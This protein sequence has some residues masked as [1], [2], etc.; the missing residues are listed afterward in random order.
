MTGTFNPENAS[1]TDL[2]DSLKFKDDYVNSMG[3]GLA[4]TTGILSGI[5]ALSSGPGHWLAHLAAG[6]KEQFGKMKAR[7]NNYVDSGKAAE[8]AKA[9]GKTLGDAA[10]STARYVAEHP[11]EIRKT[12]ETVS[13]VKRQNAESAQKVAEAKQ[14]AADIALEKEYQDWI[15]HHPDKAYYEESGEPYPSKAEYVAKKQEEAAKKKANK[16]AEERGM[17]KH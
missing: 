3:M 6:G 13:R 11:D 14:K 12:V 4:T 17:A 2:I 9:V 7:T 10:K 8:H 15:A 1:F 5:L 16:E